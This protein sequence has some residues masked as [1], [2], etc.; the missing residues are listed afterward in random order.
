V[1]F[2][3]IAFQPQA[4]TDHI[5]SQFIGG[6]PAHISTEIGCCQAKCLFNQGNKQK[7][8]GGTQQNRQVAS[9]F[10]GIDK[11]A[12]DLGVDQLGSDGGQESQPEQ[13]NLY[14]MWF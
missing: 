7:E 5:F 10:R 4:V 13:Q 12:D 6:P 1:G 9:R 14:S 3:K 2:V 8:T 11:S